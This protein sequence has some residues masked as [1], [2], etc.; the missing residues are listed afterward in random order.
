[1]AKPRRRPV[2]DFLWRHAALVA[3]VVMV[4]FIAGI[5]FVGYNYVLITR[6]FDSSRRWDLPSRIYSEATPIYAGLSYSRSLLEPK[7]NQIG[8]T[9]VSRPLKGQGEY[10]FDGEAMEI[11][12]QDFDYPEMSFTGFPVRIEFDG[13]TVQRIVRLNDGIRLKA[14]R[15][16]P[17]LITSIYDEVMEDRVPIPLEV[18]PQHLIDAIL[19]TEDR[20]F[21]THE[22]ISI[23][24][25]LRAAIQNFRKGG[26]TAGGSTLT[27][28]LVKNLYLTPERNWQRKVR[29]ILMSLILEMRYSK[30]EI[31][32]AYLNEIYLGQNGAVQINGVERA[33]EIYFA[34]HV[35]HLTVEEAATIAGM[36]RWPSRYSPLRNP[37]IA[38]ERRNLVLRMMHEQKKI[39][40]PEYRR[41]S[42]TPLSKPKF[43]RSI[44]SAPF[45]VDLVLKEL[46]ET[47]PETQLK[48]E[49]LR[50]FTTLDTIMQRSAEQALSSGVA[51]L[52]KK[53]SHIRKAEVPLE[54]VVLTIQ[55]G[56]GYV[57]ALVGGR[58]YGRS[59][60][61]RA[62][63]ARRQPGSLFKPFVYVAA[64]DPQNESTPLTAST[65]LDD[66]PITV[67]TASGAWRPQNYDNKFHGD[68]TVRRALAFSYNIPAVRAA[69]GAGVDNVIKLASRI[70]V[71]SKLEPYPSISLGSFEVTPLEVAYAYS[72]FANGGVKAEP[73]SIL[74]VVTRDG[75]VL[76]HREVKMKRVAPAAICYV[77]ND[78][79]KD[80]LDYGTAAKVRTLGFKRQYAGKTGTTNNYK[81]AWFIGYSPRLLSLVW[82]GFDDGRS[83]R[84]AGGEAAV[85]IWTSHMNRIAGLVPDS[86]FRRPD[87]VVEREVDA[88]T[89]GLASPYCPKIISEVYVSGTEPRAVCTVHSGGDFPF[90]GIPIGEPEPAMGPE[91]DGPQP[92]QPRPPER[93]RKRKKS[94]LDKIFGDLFGE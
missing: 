85:P 74:A 10:R 58:S 29:E 52:N 76:E 69:I 54:G 43:Q 16:E 82:V 20:T 57:K 21:F 4:V 60:F 93:P 14:I 72:V 27:Q 22:G 33:S 32:E 62:F 19:V 68:V 47:Y 55:P 73:I 65:L 34:K 59:Q 66:T 35:R 53:Y 88:Y 5:A 70:G 56:T 48:T 67:Q 86:D 37:E 28:Q 6:K 64:M 17:E 7:L 25:I 41:A 40:E 83:V 1:M 91:G 78:I 31:L 75:K 11:Y 71:E 9:E 45:F 46:R 3:M 26:V 2:R 51:A 15:L 44:N 42:A 89:G 63:Q 38:V 39:S 49:G 61:N 36:I 92:Q 79:L 81:D 90:F 12:L 84:L 94:L 24:G 13:S 50:I 87:D 18:V 23:R 30:K 8:Y 80:V 77:M